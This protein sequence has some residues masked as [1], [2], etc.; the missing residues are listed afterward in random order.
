MSWNDFVLHLFL[1][2]DLSLQSVYKINAVF[3]SIS[4]EWRIYFLFP[5]LLLLRRWWGTLPTTAAAVVVSYAV[6][7]VGQNTLLHHF[8]NFTITG[9]SPQY[10]ALFTLGMLAADITYG[11]IVDGKNALL[12]LLHKPVNNALLL[13]ALT[14]LLLAASRLTLRRGDILPMAYADFFVGLWTLSLL[15][16]AANS[17]TGVLHKALS[18][19]PLVFIG[20]FAYSIYL[21]HLPLI[22]LL[23]QYVFV[24]LH[25]RPLPLFLELSLVGTPLIIGVSYLFFLACERPFLNRRRRETMAETERDAALSPA[26]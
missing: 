15:I 16:A 4:V 18:W 22:Q 7:F 23:W 26:P 12:P 24:P 20:T 14:V 6:L 8:L 9:M 13:A 1:L 21:I 10:L 25:G 5:L 2:Q 17:P 19:R 3:W 11:K